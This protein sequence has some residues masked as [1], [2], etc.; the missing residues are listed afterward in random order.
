[1]N[2]LYYG[3]DLGTTNS[4]IA[5]GHMEAN[6][7]IVTR[8][9]KISRNGKEG[10]QENKDTL[11]SVVYYKK[12]FKK[13]GITAIVGDFAK[14]QYGKKYGYVMK[15]VKNYMGSYGELPLDKEIEDQSPEAISA[16]ILKHL[17]R[18][19]KEKL[20][21]DDYPRD[22]IITIPASF[23]PDM[24]EATLKAAEISGLEVKD[25]NG[26]YR[27]ILLYEPKAVIYNVINMME[28]GEIPKNTID[29][30]KE[31]NILVFDL[32]GGTLDVALYRVKNSK[33]GKF[34]IIDEIS[35]GRYT[36]IGGDTFDSLLGRELSKI[37]LEYNDLSPKDVNM[38]ELNQ[39]ME[40]KAEF[41][42]LELSDKVFN[43]K[44]TGKKIDDNEEFEIVEMGLYKGMEF[45]AYLTKKEIEN[46]L[47]PV[48]GNNLSLDFVGKMDKLQGQDINNIIYPVLD[49]L[50]KAKKQ[51]K[52]FQVDGIILNGGMTRFYLIEERLKKL[53]Q[54]DP[55]KVN[56]PDLSV[57]RGAAYYHYC[58]DKYE[59]IREQYLKEVKEVNK[60]TI[61]EKEIQREILGKVVLNETINLALDKGYVKSLVEAGRELPTGD[62]IYENLF[63]LP[64]DTNKMELPFYLGRGETTELPNRKIA[65]RVINFKRNYPK[66]TPINFIV[67]IDRNKNLTLS[68]YLGE[69]KNEIIDIIIETN[70]G[71]DGAKGGFLKI[72]TQEEKRLNVKMEL[73]ILKS[74]GKNLEKLYKE[75]RIDYKK[76]IQRMDDVLHQIS[77]CTNKVE[78]QHGALDILFTLE[79]S[80]ELKGYIF[81]LLNIIGDTLTEKSKKILLSNIKGMLNDFVLGNIR[82]RKNIKK[83]IGLLGNYKENEKLLRDLLNGKYGNIY[84]QEIAEALGKISED[85]PELLTRALKKK[86]WNLED[87]ALINSLGNIYGRGKK[88]EE[89]IYSLGDRLVNLILEEESLR[90]ISIIS[91]GK[92]FDRREIREINLKDKI[93][94]KYI[95]TLEE[96]FRYKELDDKFKEILEINLNLMK[97]LPLNGE[98]EKIYEK[99]IG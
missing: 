89:R 50:D 53:F 99:M 30:S 73:E 54:I 18:G 41:I 96:E 90:E 22:V 23:D 85:N 4:A 79:N 35:V 72:A 62:I 25:E 21:L 9:C 43:S 81:D 36:S 82:N 92:I 1:M 83:A 49:V 76:A 44:Y 67:N 64:R 20:S 88:V 80:K 91:L 34:P 74:M 94:E 5:Y 15:S 71:K 39:I 93:I 17:L 84:F 42:K 31:K 78:F 48:M 68:G 57:A 8:I 3:I 55:I 95:K 13:G 6:E 27:D 77:L 10:G 24:C 12:D 66:G 2:K 52:D 97:G 70:V 37:F 7:N 59:S 65:S 45:E 33:L 32:G 28:N 38:D 19:I 60:D 51:D 63:Y 69:N 40:G 11:P 98:E 29:F 61:K 47:N 16:Q 26:K 14:N 58:L 56:D 87:R 86:E 46:I 75:N